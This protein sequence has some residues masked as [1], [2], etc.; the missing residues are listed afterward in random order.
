[1]IEDLFPEMSSE[2]EQEEVVP[3]FGLVPIRRG[4]NPIQPV[5][6]LLENHN[7]F[8]C[9]G[10]AR[11]CASPNTGSRLVKAGDVDIYSQDEA[12]F[13]ALYAH[14]KS[15]GMEIR[16]ENDM[17]ITWLKPKDKSNPYYGCP[18]LQLIKP[19]DEG[20]IVAVGETEKI[21]ENFDFSVIRCAIVWQDDQYWVLADSDFMRDEKKKYLR[22]KNIH[23]P[24]SSML[25]FMKY[26]RKGYHTRPGQVMKLFVD[27]DSRSDMYKQ[28]LI[29]LFAA[30][31]LREMSQAQVDELE[32]LLRI[33]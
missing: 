21:L 3:D 18:V 4:L 2:E 25:R 6:E 14:F 12:T 28:R 10:Y 31:D 11:Y 9:G 8:I 19:V 1:M 15:L 7:A 29:E 24:I 33:D 30:S 22:I 17:A 23:C 16:H 27:W 20:A 5:L 32:A 26:A 13:E